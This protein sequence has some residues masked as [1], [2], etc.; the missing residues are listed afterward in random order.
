[1][2][3]YSMEPAQQQQDFYTLI[4]FARRNRI[5]LSTAYNEIKAGR[6]TAR[7]VGRRTLIAAEDERNWRERLIVQRAGN[8]A[9]VESSAR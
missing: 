7:K 4:E 2:K 3:E 8:G 5:G 1:M 6:L 9:A